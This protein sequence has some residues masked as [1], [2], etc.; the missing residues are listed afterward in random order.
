MM[1][2]TLSHYRGSDSSVG[3]ADVC[4]DAVPGATAQAGYRYR[5]LRVV[6]D[7]RAANCSPEPL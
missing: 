5:Q 4:P 6:R 1:I 3:H 2:R 7:H